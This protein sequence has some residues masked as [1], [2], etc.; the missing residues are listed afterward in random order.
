MALPEEHCFIR[1]IRVPRLA[2]HELHE[3]VRWEAE[4]AVPLPPADAVISWEILSDSVGSDHIDA[5]VAAVPRDIAESYVAALRRI[6]L[7]PVGFEPES[8]AITRA[9][10]DRN[11]RDVVLIIDLGREHTG[12]IIIRAQSVQVTANIPIAARVFTE[13]IVAAR[14][15][16]VDQAEKLKRKQ[17][18]APDGAGASLREA[19]APVLEDLVRQIKQFFSFY[20]THAHVDPTAK[21][22]I[23]S[24]AIRR[25]ILTGGD[26]IMPGLPPYLSE[27]LGVPVEVGDPFRNVSF[28]KRKFMRHPLF[29]T[30]IGLALY[31]VDIST[32]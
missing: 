21:G 3:A 25:V 5:V 4:A 30:A 19:L 14:K 13:R 26:A 8:F 22:E 24:T 31:D 20:E 11:D 27:A 16:S 17:G 29:T 6:P 12:V 7:L 23:S 15:I 32:L 10:L 1:T 9:L 28:S 18:I 2:E